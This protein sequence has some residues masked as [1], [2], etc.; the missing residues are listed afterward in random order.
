MLAPHTVRSL[1]F[2]R[3]GS[4]AHDFV[5]AAEDQMVPRLIKQATAKA[6]AVGIIIAEH[7]PWDA[8]ALQDML[9]NLP[10]VGA[11]VKTR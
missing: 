6:P 10:L 8:L 9:A 3:P 5:D 7:L 11:P 1:L 4:G 2:A